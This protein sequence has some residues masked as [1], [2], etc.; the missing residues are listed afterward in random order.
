MGACDSG[1]AFLGAFGIEGLEKR[2]SYKPFPLDPPPPNFVKPRPMK[3]G[4]E[5]LTEIGRA[6]GRPLTTVRSFVHRHEPPA[7]PTLS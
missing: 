5:T 6:V 7:C 3:N 1:R 2:Q 4:G